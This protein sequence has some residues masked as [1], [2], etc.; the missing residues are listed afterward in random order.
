VLIGAGASEVHFPTVVST[1]LL[2]GAVAPLVAAP[3][4]ALAGRYQII[5]QFH[6]RFSLIDSSRRS[7][8]ASR[9]RRPGN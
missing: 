8:T 7:Q 6:Q 2:P 3:A 4:A 1:I 9:D 5:P